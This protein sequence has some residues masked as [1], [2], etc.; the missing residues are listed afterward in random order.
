MCVFV[1]CVCAH[2]WVHVYVSMGVYM[3][4]RTCVLYAYTCI[5]IYSVCLLCTRRCL[6]LN[7]GVSARACPSDLQK[8]HGIF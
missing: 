1:L 4:V 7:L 3:C 6:A 8:V 5:H 2:M